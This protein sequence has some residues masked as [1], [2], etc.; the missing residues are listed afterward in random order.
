[1]NLLVEASVASELTGK[2]RNRV[3]CYTRYVAIL[4]EG[5]EP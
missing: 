5:T 3:F 1:M 2:K 4:M